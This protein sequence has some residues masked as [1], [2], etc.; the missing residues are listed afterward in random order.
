[1]I[2]RTC[3]INKELSEYYICGKYKDSIYYRKDCKKCF[4]ATPMRQ[5]C[6]SYSNK[7]VSKVCNR[8]KIKSRNEITSYYAKT[9]LG[10]EGMKSYELGLLPELIEIKR[11]L[12]ILKKNIRNY[13]KQNILTGNPAVN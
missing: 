7:Y 1:M 8:F 6:F 13:G 4:D 2:C 5:K 3:N 12:L 11:Q 9:I 10:F